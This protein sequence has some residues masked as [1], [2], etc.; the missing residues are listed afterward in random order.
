[1]KKLKC[2]T[3]KTDNL[4]KLLTLICHS[5]MPQNLRPQ[6]EESEIENFEIEASKIEASK[7]YD[8]EIKIPR[9]G[10]LKWKNLKIKD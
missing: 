3:N 2:Q 5:F 8:L 7:I 9:G 10:F 6:I 1:M 4:E